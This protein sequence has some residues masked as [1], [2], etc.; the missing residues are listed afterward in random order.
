MRALSLVA[1]LLMA[2]TAAAAEP[3]NQSARTHF[4]WGADFGSSI[5][6]SGHDMSSIDFNADFGV[7]HG[8]LSLAGVGAG[9]NIM[10]SNSCR[11][12]PIFA[13]LRTSLSPGRRLAFLDV[14]G[15]VALNYLTD[16]L[17]KTSPYV[18]VGIGF[19]L[20][21]GRT[22]Q[23]YIVAAYTYNG[24]GDVETSEISRHYEPLHYAG[25]RLGIEF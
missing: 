3:D 6:L 24:R 14:R 18:S 23:S 22:F 7:S 20:A 5:D 10:V 12:Y 16:N 17:S 11:T 8:W 2:L 15:G 4:A 13:I 19:N 1:A 9:V 25:V 21:G